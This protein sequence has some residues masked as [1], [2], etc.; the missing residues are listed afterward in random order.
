MPEVAHKLPVVK[1]PQ[2]RD[3]AYMLGRK[4]YNE[5]VENPNHESLAYFKESCLYM[6]RV[7]QRLKSMIDYN[8][9]ANYVVAVDS[10]EDQPAEGQIVRK[11][12]ILQELEE[13]FTNGA[14]D[15]REQKA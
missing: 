10:P 7:Q 13:S 1:V 11:S 15:C 3:K 9:E 6:N 4:E 14:L 12:E 8:S 5:K 2:A